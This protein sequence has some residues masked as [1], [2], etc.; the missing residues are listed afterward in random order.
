MRLAEYSPNTRQRLRQLISPL[1]SIDNPVD[2]AWTGSNFEGSREIF[3]AVLEDDGVDAVIVAFISFELSME[4][5]KAIIDVAKHY[6]KPIM[7]C[8]GS[9]GAAVSVVEALEDASIPTYPFPDRAT[10][11][12][13]GLVRYGQIL[14]IID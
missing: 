2:M 9:L 3:K 14:K 12:L 13:A 4:L 8:L 5:P 6:T 7:V 10:T 11:G 1:L